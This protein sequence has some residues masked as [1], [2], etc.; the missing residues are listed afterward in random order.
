[1]DF[2]GGCESKDMLIIAAIVVVI[3]LLVRDG[4]IKL[5]GL[6]NSNN[7]RVL[8]VNPDLMGGVGRSREGLC[9]REGVVAREVDAVELGQRAWYGM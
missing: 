7:Q 5:E 6:A 4:K 3:M 2:S 9:V 8:Q 1:M